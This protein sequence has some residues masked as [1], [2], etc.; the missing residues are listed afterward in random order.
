MKKKHMKEYIQDL[1]LEL[2]SISDGRYEPTSLTDPGIYEFIKQIAIWE[3]DSNRKSVLV[4]MEDLS[5]L[6]YLYMDGLE[7]L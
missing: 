7:E 6:T 4:N 1:E 2:E 5:T 3:Q